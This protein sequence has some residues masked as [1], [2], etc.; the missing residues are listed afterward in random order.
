M[1]KPGQ[2]M[3]LP[4]E[5]RNVK[6]CSGQRIM[7]SLAVSSAFIKVACMC[8][9]LRCTPRRPD[10]VRKMTIP[11]PSRFARAGYLTLSGRNP[12]KTCQS[13]S[14]DSTVVAADPVS[15]SKSR[16]VSVL[17]MRAASRCH[18]TLTGNLAPAA[19][20]EGLLQSQQQQ[21]HLHGE[22]LFEERG[23]DAAKRLPQRQPVLL[24]GRWADVL[25]LQGLFD[26]EPFGLR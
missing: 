22:I 19:D 14:I 15:A 10:F 25:Q 11:S 12:V 24:S 4:S 26:L 1:R 6:T 13:L 2:L 18:R 20:G 17:A 21:A 23:I 9:Q 7:V 3:P 16:V 8:A 5:R